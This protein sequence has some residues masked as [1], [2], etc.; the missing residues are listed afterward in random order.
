MRV[1]NSLLDLRNLELLGVRSECLLLWHL[2]NML[3]DV[4]WLIYDVVRATNLRLVEAI[5]AE[6]K[7]F[8]DKLRFCL[9][10][11]VLRTK[12]F[13]NTASPFILGEITLLVVKII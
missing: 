11:G 10:H 6:I 13:S 12:L 3:P 5:S 8:L 2:M 7:F 4:N 1:V 9:R